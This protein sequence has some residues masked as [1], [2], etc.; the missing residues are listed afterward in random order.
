M[1]NK[2]AGIKKK[3]DGTGLAG[4]GRARPARLRKMA[5]MPKNRPEKKTSP[6]HPP[7]AALP[8]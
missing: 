4:R 1:Q 7:R 2:L 8:A 5:P 6:V 3:V